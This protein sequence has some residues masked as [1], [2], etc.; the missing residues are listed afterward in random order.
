[1]LLPSFWC[2]TMRLP[3]ADVARRLDL[4]VSTIERWIRQGR[5][6]ARLQR[7]EVL[8]DLRE[9]QEWARRRN[10]VLQDS[11][12]SGPAPSEQAG[13][14]TTDLLAAVRRGG[15][16]AGI[17]GDD[18]ASVFKAAV[19]VVPIA[20]EHRALLLQSLLEREELASTGIG[21]GVAIPHPRSPLQQAI[22]QPLVTTCFLHE[23]LDLDAVDGQPVFVL[24]LLLSPA[25]KV[26]LPLLSQLAYLLRDQGFVSFLR[27][28]PGSEALSQRIAEVRALLARPGAPGR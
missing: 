3:I 5:I 28:Q 11:T 8:F 24:F 12:H 26:H 20:D 17:A 1:M 25:V 6:P 16:H 2:L 18:L 7:D 10:L 22:D 21:N 14:D 19:A 27:S 23:P 15:V 4:P 13:P 9:L